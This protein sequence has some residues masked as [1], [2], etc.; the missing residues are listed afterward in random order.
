MKKYFSYI[1][2]ILFVLIFSFF[3][4]KDYFLFHQ[5]NW[6]IQKIDKNSQESILD[7]SLS[8]IKYLSGSELYYT[9][10]K[11]LKNKIIDKI[12]NA[13]EKV[14]AEVYI[15]TE[16]NIRQAIIN[17]KKR[18]LDVKVILEKNPYNAYNI[19][20]TSY[21]LFKKNWVDIVW[22]NPENY[23][24]NHS[25]VLIIDDE[26][27]I[28]TWNISHSLFNYNR[29]FLFLT[30][31]KAIHDIVF[32]I[33]NHDFKWEKINLYN[34][35]LVLSPFYSRDKLEKLIDSANIS[36]NMYFQYL[37]DE[38]MLKKI[39]EARKNKIKVS[40]IMSSSS[41]ESGKEDIDRLIKSWVDIRFVKTPKIHSK[42]IMI[43]EKYVY[44]W[45][46]NFS[47]YSMDKN[48][49]VGII[50]KNEDLIKKILWVFKKDFE[51]AYFNSFS[52]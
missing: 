44:I 51:N 34:E 50:F 29:D 15:F 23:S 25:K 12:N 5:N 14:Y 38:E 46:I 28:S 35:N 31:D 41:Q 1:F 4:W 43:D 3:Y 49:E 32:N 16:K 45:S 8:D 18:G 47:R 27:I 11:D 6:D 21:N 36:I 22:S 30:K 13:G 40:L 19:N 10:Y 42:M 7:F 9:P 33:F 24:L 37:S 52:K 39:L 26:V 48:R 2:I 20:N 17:A